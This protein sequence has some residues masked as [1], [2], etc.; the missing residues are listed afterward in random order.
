MEKIRRSKVGGI[1]RGGYNPA[2]ILMRGSG[3]SARNPREMSLLSS[4]RSLPQA[5]GGNQINRAR[6]KYCTALFWKKRVY[7]AAFVTL[8]CFD[9]VQR[10]EGRLYWRNVFKRR[11]ILF[12]T[13]NT[14]MCLHFVFTEVTLVVFLSKNTSDEVW[15][16][17]HVVIYICWMEGVCLLG[18]W[19]KGSQMEDLR[20]KCN[21]SKSPHDGL[22]WYESF[23]SW[24]LSGLSWNMS[25]TCDETLDTRVTRITYYFDVF[26]RRL[27]WP[28]GVIHILMER[29]GGLF[30]KSYDWESVDL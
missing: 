11:I 7:S 3:I 16:E 30:S 23:P 27:R 24:R 25:V 28:S 13:N 26:E 10:R 5:E 14:I 19:C 4:D 21:L 6:N 17:S 2:I 20:D 22:Q 29:G 15:W 8:H 9:K 18:N 12:F 1:G